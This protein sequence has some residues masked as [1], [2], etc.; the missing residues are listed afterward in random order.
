MSVGAS[1]AHAQA[2][3]T[4]WWIRVN[5]TKTEASSISFQI[6][7]S[8][9]ASR[10]WRR[11]KSGQRVEFDVPADFRKAAQLY[12][13]ATSNPHDKKASFCAFYKDHGV[14]YFEFD[15][16][17]DHDMKPDHSDDDCKP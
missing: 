2:R 11:W 4:G 6:G 12:I 13:R 14:E 5:T 17:E 9:D 3:K 8:K 15:G 7:T 16:D 10:N 1:S